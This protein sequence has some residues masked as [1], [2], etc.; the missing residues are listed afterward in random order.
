MP[1]AEQSDGKSTRR[2]L[3]GTEPNYRTMYQDIY[4]FTRIYLYRVLYNMLLNIHKQIMDV[5]IDSISARIH[6][7]CFMMLYVVTVCVLSAMHSNMKASAII[8][9]NII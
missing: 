2:S 7:T 4:D 6:R 3:Q 8:C 5:A 9:A 1:Q